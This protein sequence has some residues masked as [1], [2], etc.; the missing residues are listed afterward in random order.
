MR[1]YLSCCGFEVR[2]AQ[3]TPNMYLARLDFSSTEVALGQGSGQVGGVAYD[4]VP[5]E[6]SFLPKA[7]PQVFQVK[8]NVKCKKLTV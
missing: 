6:V 1:L 5:P 8:D 3:Y 7:F 4:L 2:L